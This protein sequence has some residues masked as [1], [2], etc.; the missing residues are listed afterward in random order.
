LTLDGIAKSVGT[1]PVHLARAFRQ[2]HYCTIGEYIRKLRVEFACCEITTTDSSLAEIAARTGFYDQ[3]HFSRTFK[4]I[5]GV[6]PREYRA[7]FRS[8]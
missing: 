5:I 4:R 1:H 3:S 7:A 6:T 2:H 8:R